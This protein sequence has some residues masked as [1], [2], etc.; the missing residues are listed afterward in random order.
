MSYDAQTAAIF[1]RR[2]GQART[3]AQKDQLASVHRGRRGV[4][5]ND[6]GVGRR[7]LGILLA[8]VAASVREPIRGVVS[9]RVLAAWCGVN[10]RTVRRWLNGTDIPQAHAV[11]RL[12]AWIVRAP[13]LRNP[14][15]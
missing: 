7:Q 11:A 10:D 9:I 4:R 6:P 5:V 15:D 12:K 2:G 14:A 13:R 8:S 3:K 1:G